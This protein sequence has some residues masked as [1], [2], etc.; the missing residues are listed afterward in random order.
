MDT[1]GALCVMIAG[2]LQMLEWCADNWDMK[3]AVSYASKIFAKTYLPIKTAAAH[4]E[5]FF[6]EGRGPIVLDEVQC[7][8]M[9]P[10]ISSCVHR[11]LFEHDCG[12]NE[13]ASV[14]CSLT[15]MLFDNPSLHSLYI[16]HYMILFSL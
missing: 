12:H 2:T 15:G 3:E 14:V 1:S 11:G 8:G 5:A 9:E 16:T 4:S 6:G 13:D 10:N 7:S